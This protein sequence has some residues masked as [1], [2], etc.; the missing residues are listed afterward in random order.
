MI[1][2]HN[3]ERGTSLRIFCKDNLVVSYKF[4]D[5]RNARKGVGRRIEKLL[6]LKGRAKP[7]SD[8]ETLWNAVNIKKSFLVT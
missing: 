7:T 3:L 4:C 1:A 2:Q 5:H 6:L 8:G